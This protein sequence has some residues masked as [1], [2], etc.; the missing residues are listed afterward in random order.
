MDN[1]V[2][3]G[4]DSESGSEGAA[5]S[6]SSSRSSSPSREEENGSHQSGSSVPQTGTPSTFEANRSDAVN[7]EPMDTDDN[8]IQQPNTPTP[9]NSLNEPSEAV[10]QLQPPPIARTFADL[11]PSP[12]GEI[13]EELQDKFDRLFKMKFEQRIDMNRMILQRKDFK[14]PSIYDK[15][16]EEYGVNEYGTNYVDTGARDEIHLEESDYYDKLAEE[17][18]RVI[19]QEEKRTKV[20]KK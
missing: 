14:N 4:S 7:L 19:E 2:G 17:Q 18:S 9:L 1:L 20:G 6:R 5:N 3:Y 10:K 13:D 11:P 8:S 16:K 12:T 15:M